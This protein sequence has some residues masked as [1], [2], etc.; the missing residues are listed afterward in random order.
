MILDWYQ[1]SDRILG[2]T[3]VGSERFRVINP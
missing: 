2:I 1:G 3:A